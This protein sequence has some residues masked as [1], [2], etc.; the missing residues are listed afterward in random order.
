MT[1]TRILV[2]VYLGAIV[3]ANLTIAALGPV[4]VIPVGI[5]LIG[6]DLT[7]RDQ[8]HDAWARRGV[9]E[10]VLRMGALIA[11]G[12]ILSYALNEDAGRVALASC[13]AFT[14]AA[15]VDLIG[16]ELLRSRRPWIRSAA[17]SAPAALVDSAVFLTILT[18][19]LP[20]V[21]IAGQ[22]LAKA[23]GAAV[24]ARLLYGP[25]P[26][27]P[28]TLEEAIRADLGHRPA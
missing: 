19:G 15:M 18:G 7:T 6:L 8:L 1:A 16:Y 28:R 26:R 25:G 2:A 22:A 9:L 24:W 21:L 13:A 4:A 23:A 20:L 14:A 3:A 12:G 17:S 10:F 11:A 5:A 27:A